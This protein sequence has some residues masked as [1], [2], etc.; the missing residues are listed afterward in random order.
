MKQHKIKELIKYKNF[1]AI[2]LIMYYKIILVIRIIFK[3]NN[4]LLI[5]ITIKIVYV[6][7]II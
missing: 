1:Q 4:C 2:L 7:N 5:S 6:D 3:W